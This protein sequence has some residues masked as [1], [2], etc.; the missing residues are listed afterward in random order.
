MLHD[1]AVRDLETGLQDQTPFPLAEAVDIVVEIADAL[2]RTHEL[3][4]VS[5]RVATANILVERGPF[6]NA[7]LRPRA[8]GA[9]TRTNQSL[10]AHLYLAPEQLTESRELDATTDIWSLAVILYE[11][12]SGRPPFRDAGEIKRGVFPPLASVRNGCP[13]QLGMAIMSCLQVEPGA[14]TPSIVSFALEIA[15]FGGSRTEAL[16]PALKEM[17]GPSSERTLYV[18]AETPTVP[19]ETERHAADEEGSTVVAPAA[20]EQEPD[21]E[22]DTLTKQT[23]PS[24]FKPVALPTVP[25]PFAPVS[26]PA[27]KKQPQDDRTQRISSATL[28][29]M[30]KFVTAARAQKDAASKGGQALA[31]VL[32]PPSSPELG[33]PI[34]NI[35]IRGAGLAPADTPPRSTPMKPKGSSLPNVVSTIALLI[36]VSCVVAAG[37]ILWRGRKR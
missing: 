6:G 20:S 4:A 29:E 23:A 17:E 19:P 14:R 15:Q 13:P 25:A 32:R 24:A 36:F 18:A 1:V 26:R 35:R 21:D 8:G 37:V 2:A 28:Q 12:L 22:P 11:L 30:G 27:Q 9:A 5:G 10:R 3:G 16:V 31:P 34:S 7:K 33:T